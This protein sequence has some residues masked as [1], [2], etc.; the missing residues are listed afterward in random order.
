[1]KVS[2]L[3][4]RKST[5]TPTSVTVILLEFNWQET[6]LGLYLLAFEVGLLLQGLRVP[7]SDFSFPVV[8]ERGF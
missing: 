4:E 7:T 6:L 1:M 2:V 5:G 8:D 3:T